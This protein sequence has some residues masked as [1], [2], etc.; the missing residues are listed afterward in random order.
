M[1]KTGMV[2][3]LVLM[4]AVV[5]LIFVVVK[6]NHSMKSLEKNITK[7]TKDAAYAN[8]QSSMKLLQNGIES[9]YESGVSVY[10]MSQ[11]IVLCRGVNISPKFDYNDAIVFS[12]KSKEEQGEYLQYIKDTAE[13]CHN[14]TSYLSPEFDNGGGQK[15]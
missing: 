1:K 15:D 6:Q 8:V 4:I 14:D 13:K 9:G 2:A 11:C 3:Q 10:L 7:K 12:D 5:F